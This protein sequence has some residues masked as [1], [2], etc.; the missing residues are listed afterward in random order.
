MPT[1]IF[2]IAGQRHA[3]QAPD[4]A[5]A[6][7]YAQRF[8]AQIA[9]R[10]PVT[11]ADIQQRLGPNFGSDFR[12]RVAD[13]VGDLNSSIAEVK[14]HPGQLMNAQRVLEAVGRYVP[15]A[16]SLVPAAAADQLT[17]PV[18]SALNNRLGT[19]FDTHATTDNV[20]GAAALATGAGE[21]PEAISLALPAARA[22]RASRLASLARG[23]EL[24]APAREAAAAAAPEAPIAAAEPAPAAET[25][26][27]EPQSAPVPRGR[28]PV[29][30]DTAPAPEGPRPYLRPLAYP[31][32]Q[33]LP[34]YRPYVD[35]FRDA[36]NNRVE[37]LA[38]QHN[39]GAAAYFD[40]LASP[41]VFGPIYDDPD[42]PGYSAEAIDKIHSSLK[43]I[44]G[45]IYQ[46]IP[47]AHPV[48][49]QLEK[50]RDDFDSTIGQEEF[51]PA[52]HVDYKTP[53]QLGPVNTKVVKL[54]ERQ[55]PPP[56]T[57]P[58]PQEIQDLLPEPDDDDYEERVAWVKEM[59]HKVIDHIAENKGKNVV[60]F[61]GAKAA[62][63]APAPE[64][65][66]GPDAG[67][68][69]ADPD[70]SAAAPG[71]QATNA[72]T[73]QAILQNLAMINPQT[74][75]GVAYRRPFGNALL[76]PS[77]TGAATGFAGGQNVGDAAG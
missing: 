3:F 30:A 12:S 40:D 63:A 2:N 17:R 53:L 73:G 6:A 8:A 71:P 23:L 7:R 25:A 9:G 49:N 67:A 66:A 35:T 24:S 10:A 33:Q 51:Q 1:F 29:P 45:E 68:Q 38:Q 69:P 47:D 15:N 50:L 27:E 44:A 61:P 75:G 20:L 74:A 58:L 60:A 31:G 72:F 16:L 76:P 22:A 56:Q 77:I 52:R 14:A 43:D 54:S 64:A 11:T 26:S 46:G 4:Q 48:A 39:E 28:Q 18:V 65:A 34:A 42:I 21:V 70:S 32:A 13:A 59:L 55:A 37:E 36:Y 57:N 5:S 19:N 62:P 41:V